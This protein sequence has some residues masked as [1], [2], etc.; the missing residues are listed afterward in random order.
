MKYNFACFI[1]CHGRPD[2]TPTYDTLRKYGFS[3]DIY[4]ICDDEDKTLPQYIE[5]YG[6]D[7][8]KVFN[9]LQI[10]KTFDV[11]DSSDNRGCAV[12]ARNT[13]FDIARELNIDYF[14]ELDDDYLDI[15]IRKPIENTLPVFKH[16][17]LDEIFEAYIDFMNTNENIYSVAFAQAGDY[18]GGYGCQLMHNGYKRKCMNSWICNTQ[19]RFIFN[20]RMNDDVNTYTLEG[21]RGKVFMT[22]PYVCVNQPETQQVVGG[23]T[24]MY[25]GEG[26]YIKTFYTVM[27]C[28]SFAKVY[29]MGFHNHRIHHKILWE[30]ACPKIISDKYKKY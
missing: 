12:Y 13:C 29:T 15:T 26:T 27:C 19:K 16:T 11:M 28:P 30:H 9:K 17:N 22:L 10:L 7:Y 18:I 1:L 3:G 8:V 20:G 23:M 2:N 24:E 14:C 6:N 5:R 25:K 21:S 4:I